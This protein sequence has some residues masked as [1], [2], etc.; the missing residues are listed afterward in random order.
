M[1]FYSGRITLPQDFCCHHVDQ[2]S[3]TWSPLTLTDLGEVNFLAGHIVIR[4]KIKVPLVERWELDWGLVI[5]RTPWGP[6]PNLHGLSKLRKHICGSLQ[7]Q[8]Q[9]LLGLHQQP[10]LTQ[11]FLLHLLG[12]HRPRNSCCPLAKSC[13]TLC[14]P[15][16]CSMQAF[17]VLHCLPKSSQTHV[18]WVSDATQ[19]SHPLSPP[20]PLALNLSQHQGLFQWVGSSHQVAKVLELQLQHQSF[21][22]IFRVDFL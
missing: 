14:N 2:N 17:S 22:W 7:W 1:P 4:S 9:F 19:L 10:T 5:C 12:E 6:R 15:M 8:G 21:Q 11:G 18:H 3:T 16:N 20:S 13:L